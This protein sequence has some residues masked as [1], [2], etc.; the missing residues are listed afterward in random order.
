[1]EKGLKKK[2]GKRERKKR[3]GGLKGALHLPP[4]DGPKIVLLKEM[5]R[6]IATKL[7]QK[8][9]DFEFLTKRKKRKK[10]KKEK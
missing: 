6:E 9:S 2:E 1:M 8:N 5:L 10:K 3:I 4:R 7:R